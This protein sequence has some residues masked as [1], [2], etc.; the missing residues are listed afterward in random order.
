MVVIHLGEEIRNTEAHIVVE[1][2][3]GMVLALVVD[4]MVVEMMPYME[5]D[6]D[7]DEMAFDLLC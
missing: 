6:M 3:S 7:L 5:A 1:V 2:P 4:T